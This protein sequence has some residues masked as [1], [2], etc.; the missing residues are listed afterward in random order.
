MTVKEYGDF[1]SSLKASKQTPISAA[2]LPEQ[3]TQAS[4]PP[5]RKKRQRDDLPWL[6]QRIDHPESSS[7]TSHSDKPYGIRWRRVRQ[8]AEDYYDDSE[9][10][11]LLDGHI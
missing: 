6:Q 9:V 1:I 11:I 3:G 2:V 4:I 8:Q 10:S 5:K 7:D